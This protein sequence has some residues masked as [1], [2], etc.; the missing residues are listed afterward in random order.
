MN[1][2][3]TPQPTLLAVAVALSITI[4]GFTTASAQVA[5]TPTHTFSPAGTTGTF[6]DAANWTPGLPGAGNAPL[7]ADGKTA[8]TTQANVD[9]V[10][11]SLTL[12][13]GSTMNLAASGKQGINNFPVYFSNNSQLLFT[14]G[15]VN[16]SATYNILAASTATFK[17]AGSNS[18]SIVSGSVNGHADSVFNVQLLNSNPIR[19]RWNTTGMLGTMNYVISSGAQ[20][21]DLSNF[22]P[23]NSAVGPGVTN[24]ATNVRAVMGA[25]DRISNTATVVLTGSSGGASNVKFAMGGTSDTIG[26]LTIDSPTGATASAPTLQ[27]SSALTVTGTTTFQGTAGAVN[28][29]STA[30]PTIN[31]LLTT[32]NMT[33]DGTGT[34]AVSGDDRIRLNAA[35]GTRTVTT[36]ADASI[37]NTLTGT[38]G[39]TKEGAGTLTLTGTNLYRGTA[40]VNAGTLSVGNG[41]SSTALS[42]F[43]GL[44]VV[45][46]AVVN[47]NY[48][49]SDT[50]LALSLGGTPMAAGQYGHTDSGAD[51]GGAGVGFYDAYFAPNTGIINN[52]DGDTSLIGILFWD[53]GVAN[54]GTNGDA[55]AAGGTGTWN[56]TLTNW[57]SGTGPHVAWDNSNLDTAVLEGAAGT[58]T[59][60]APITAGGI[61]STSTSTIQS[62]TLTLDVTSGTPVVNVA[63]NTLTITSDIA[64]ND[65]LQKTGPGTLL[66][67]GNKSFSGGL[68]LSQGT[69]QVNNASGVFG[70]GTLTI[71]GGEI[72]ANANGQ[73]STTTNNHIWNNSFSI[74][75]GATGSATFNFDGDVTLANNIT[76]THTDN[77]VTTRINGDIGQSGGNRSL[78]I[79]AG[80]GSVILAG[81][82]STY[83][84]A[85]NL[86]SGTLQLA[87]IDAISSSSGLAASTGTTLQLRSDTADTFATPLTTLNSSGGSSMTIDVNRISSGSGNQLV[88]NG[89]LSSQ[90]NHGNE[91]TLNFTGG[92]AYTLSIPTLKIDRF[93]GGGGGGGT[94][95]NPTTT[96]VAIG[97]VTSSATQTLFLR[98]TGTTTGNTLGAITHTG[99]AL[100][101]QKQG[102]GTWTLTGASN[103][104]GAVAITAGSLRITN[105]TSLGTT[106]GGV[107]QSGA[108]EL[109]I[110]GSSGAVTVGSEALSI[111]GGGISNAGALRN[112]AGNNTYGGTVTLAAQSRIN[113]DSGTLVLN[114]ATSVTGAGQNLVVGGAGNISISGAITTTT[115]FVTKDGAG[116]LTLS[117]GNTYSGATTVSG[118][119]LKLGANN[120]IPNASN[121]TI[122]AATLDADTRTDTAGTLDVTGAAVINLGS[123][124]ALAFADS[125]AVDWTGGTLNITGTLDATSLR[126]GDSADDLTGDQL[127]LIS[128]NGSGTGTYVLD[129]DGYLVAGGGDVTPPEWTATW[130]KVDTQTTTGFTVRANTNEDGTAYYVVL[131]DGA[132]APSAA[133]VKAGTAAGGGSA[134]ANGSISLTA[135]NENTAAVTGLTAGTA[136][137]VYFVAEDDVPNL[138]ASPVKVDAS[139]LSLFEDWAAGYELTGGDA[140]PTANPDG[141]AFTNLQEF[142]FGFNPTVSDGAGPLTISGGSI[143]QNGPPQIYVDPVTGQY[144]LRYTRRTD[145]VAAGLTYLQEFAADSLGSGSFQNV[146][147]GSVVATGTGAGGVAL[148]AVAIEFPDA[149]PGSGKKARYARVGVNQTP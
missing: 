65:G 12:G 103:F 108:S 26:N 22:A 131:A 90:Q 137:D 18:D 105:N 149:L 21:V 129:D 46:P 69:L 23:S 43:G 5:P 30:F 45:S 33:F 72:R 142:A 27:G 107:T 64:G 6:S 141:D 9:T 73:T 54:I 52:L 89:G 15:D 40:T 17:P 99:S 76:L 75:R 111:N 39:F 135:N 35:S 19:T 93:G 132:T 74:S 81:D 2:Y 119:T 115:G 68:T 25:S 24:F 136:Y 85:T 128:V 83:A 55:I 88:L 92:N 126:F 8:T 145:Y 66:L 86:N 96:S 144:F 139:T 11:G 38:Q 34:W 116:M 133:E 57:D 59:L 42:D 3:K 95:L 104:T 16:R 138:Q 7:I 94:H 28:I 82:N 130:P 134:L 29:D 140:L 121:V 56:T 91:T 101:L 51:N 36:T 37:S 44:A 112:I 67:T 14:S 32:G 63:A 148:Q 123:G 122:G 79:A 102:T 4:L 62:N 114:N 97:P 1:P 61:Q 60:G 41:T 109:A 100:T 71:G 48:T 50:V 127:A 58:V 143:T 80:G 113:S 47:L 106:A 117:G 125:K 13:V 118:G 87:H 124:A 147:G 53:G 49:G 110:D 70:T 78:S 120:V 146:A 31:D 10:F 77:T 98:L 84:G 20:S